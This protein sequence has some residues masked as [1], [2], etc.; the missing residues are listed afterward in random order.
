MAM[1]MSMKYVNCKGEV[2]SLGDG[3]PLHY[4]AN[5]LRD[6]EWTANEVNGGV[7]AFTRSPIDKDLPIGIAADDE[8]QG[9]L[10]RDRIYEIAEHD[11]SVK[12][13]G[14]LYADKSWYLEL[15]V[16]S[17]SFD[18]YHFDERFAE[19]TMGCRIPYP[20]WIREVESSYFIESDTQ[21][22]STSLDYPYDY[23]HDYIRPR[24]SKVINN[25]SI[26]PCDFMLRIYGPATNPSVTIANNTH[27]VEVTVPS[28]AF[29]EIDTRK[30]HRRI[31]L[32]D[33]Y[34]NV[35]N[36]YDKRNK[37]AVGSGKFIWQRIPVGFSQLTWNN[38][39]DFDIVQYQ[40]R[41][42]PPWS[43]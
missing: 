36:C 21:I 37:S 24:S 38:S 41:S 13:P 35:T 30:A 43:R 8:E 39:F 34:G 32:T 12:S 27:Q 4:F 31:Q 20:A 14:R 1:D 19:M 25:D 5:A 33:E 29:L 6:W 10:I 9:L 7:S 23:P 3:G 17:C 40:E 15:F 42:T 18:K 28:G 16:L 2:L 22:A 26:Y 11:I